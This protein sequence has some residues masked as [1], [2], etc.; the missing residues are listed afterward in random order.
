MCF[1]WGNK[2]NHCKYA[3]SHDDTCVWKLSFKRGNRWWLLKSSVIFWS[4]GIQVDFLKRK[5]MFFFRVVTS[6]GV[7]CIYIICDIIFKTKHNL[8]FPVTNYG[9]L[10]QGNKWVLVL[11][12]FVFVFLPVFVFIF[13][14]SRW[15]TNYGVLCQAINGY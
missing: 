1:N 2:C 15:V 14:F 13:V 4:G 10:C 5:N 6:D 8:F 7:L 11:F 9:A 12:V 3:S